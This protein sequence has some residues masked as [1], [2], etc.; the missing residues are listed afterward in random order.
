[1]TKLKLN[2][3]ERKKIKK[4][5]NLV[6]DDIRKLWAESPIKETY[7]YIS[8]NNNKYCK[9]IINDEAIYIETSF[10][11]PPIYLEQKMPGNITKR[12]YDDDICVDFLKQYDKVRMDIVNTIN[13]HS[14]RK[15]EAFKKLDEIIKK[16]DK[17]SNIEVDLSKTKTDHSVEISKKDGKSIGKI[18]LGLA[19]LKVT[20]QSDIVLKGNDPQTQKNKN[21]HI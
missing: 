6:L 19:N 15:K 12:T 18:N 11:G 21:K 4:S 20:S 10:S 9:L 5:M 8:I 2:K 7:E 14:R 3:E 1:M 13:I 16:Y 17:K